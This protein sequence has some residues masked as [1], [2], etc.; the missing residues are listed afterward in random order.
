MR[1]YAKRELMRKEIRQRA[2]QWAI[3]LS[4]LLS[5]VAQSQVVTDGSMGGTT[6]IGGP[7]YIIPATLGQ[8]RG[9][10]LFHSFSTFNIAASESALF[11]TT[12]STTNIIARITGGSPSNING[13]ITSP[14]NLFFLNPQGVMFGSGASVNVNG[15]FH[16]STADYLRFDDGSRFYSN[17]SDTSVLTTV[18]PTAFGFL[19]S[20]VGAIS[21]NNSRLLQSSTRSLSLIGGNITLDNSYIGTPGGRIN[22]ASVASVGEVAFGVNSLTATGF[23][24][25]GDIRLNQSALNSDG[26]QYLETANVYIRGG[27][28]VME[29]T[30]GVVGTTTLGGSP[31]TVDVQVDSLVVGPYSGIEVE[32]FGGGASTNAVIRARDIDVRGGDQESPSGILIAGG[33]FSPS[34][35]VSIQTETLRLSGA[36]AI[37]GTGV[38][39]S[40]GRAGNLTIQASSVEILDNAALTALSAGP[41]DGGFINIVTDT[42]TLRDR[43]SI[44]SVN[45]SGLLGVPGG[46]NAGPISISARNV[47]I[48]N[49]SVIV[50]ANI[51][52]GNA[53]GISVTAGDSLYVRNGSAISTQA[54]QG[55]GGNIN[56]SANRFVVSGSRISTSV[57]GASGSGGNIGVGANYIAL[58]S[59]SEISASAVG[60]N[61]GNINLA[62]W[63]V[64]RAPGSVID[65]SSQLGVDG[66]VEISGFNVD[67]YNEVAALPADFLDAKQWLPTPCASRQGNDVSQFVVTGRDGVHES[68][69]DLLAAPLTLN[70][71]TSTTTSQV[72][73]QTLESFAFRPLCLQGPG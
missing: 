12:V 57:E 9:G 17:L 64:L 20:N 33:G 63:Y 16:V 45:A 27:R 60:G 71:L 13:R 39:N 28:F 65:A 47:S 30:S 23:T 5:H 59:N 22:V 18:P 73:A 62:A 66:R 46:G 52:A 72:T 53:G 55:V 32:A 1:P 21:L 6:N 51:G 49:T 11:T 35:N 68:P 7:G 69:A 19:D 3:S 31:R 40:I 44:Q 48:E 36:G 67:V 56:L 15:T 41:G 38:V 29:N 2:L 58:D 26:F 37:I 54:T 25:M 43:G 61:G 8:Q 70:S 4:V 50:A 10:N 24:A 14:T 42:L 34:G